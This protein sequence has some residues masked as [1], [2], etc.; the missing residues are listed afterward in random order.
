M[1]QNNKTNNKKNVLTSTL[2]TEKGRE[3]GSSTGHSFHQKEKHNIFAEHIELKKLKHFQTHIY[4]LQKSQKPF[5][6]EH[7]H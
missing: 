6:N 2:F 3:N 7:F 5:L 1:S 4:R